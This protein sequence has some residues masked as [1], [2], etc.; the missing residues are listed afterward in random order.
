MNLT[1]ALAISAIG[2]F[3]I[4][5]PLGNLCGLIPRPKPADLQISYYKI[6]SLESEPKKK[7][8][9]TDTA[10]SIK[11]PRALQKQETGAAIEKPVPKKPLSEKTNTARRRIAAAA[12]PPKIKPQE[13]A[14]VKRES[15]PPPS[16]PGTTMPNTP[17]CMSYYKYIREEIK[18][19]LKQNYSRDYAEGDVNISFVI[20]QNGELADLDVIEERSSI[21]SI[22]RRLSYDSVQSSSPF[23]PF[24]KSLLQKQ[25]SFNLTVVFKK[26]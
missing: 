5:L 2:H 9:R 12:K 1:K 10:E 13:A 22:L 24:P 23:K 7:A 21:N 26:E 6:A 3:V 8:A 14:P 11:T 25:I 19:F 18:K 15:G 16:I 4:M 20:N 17:E